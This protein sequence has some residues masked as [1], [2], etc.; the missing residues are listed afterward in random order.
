M[1][2]SKR[3]N[4]SIGNYTITITG[5]ER[6]AN[7]AKFTEIVEFW[8]FAMVTSTTILGFGSRTFPGLDQGS[9]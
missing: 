9:W 1:S 2:G 4:H 7:Q 3:K 8:H 5:S 6:P